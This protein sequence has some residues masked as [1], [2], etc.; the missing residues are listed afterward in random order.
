MRNG[1]VIKEQTY[2]QNLKS[3]SG[4]PIVGVVK[5]SRFRCLLTSQPSQ[6]DEC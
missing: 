1:P 4:N 3:R 6:T 2:N 5:R